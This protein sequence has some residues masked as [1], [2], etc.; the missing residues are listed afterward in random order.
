MFNWQTSKST[1][2]TGIKYV[3]DAENIP[4]MDNSCNIVFDS[5]KGSSNFV[6]NYNV[7]MNNSNTYVTIH[8]LNIQY[9]N[10]NMNVYTKNYELETFEVVNMDVYDVLNRL[11]VH[12]SNCFI[13]LNNTLDVYPYIE[14]LDPSVVAHI[15]DT[16]IT[17]NISYNLLNTVNIPVANNVGF[18]SNYALYYSYSNFYNVPYYLKPQNVAM[19]TTSIVSIT[20]NVVSSVNSTLNSNFINVHNRIITNLKLPNNISTYNKF[21]TVINNNINY[22]GNNGIYNNIFLNTTTSNTIFY[23]DRAYYTGNFIAEK[24]NTFNVETSI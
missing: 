18:G 9:M 2:Y 10:S 17:S 14:T 11:I 1:Y 21:I 24:T 7:V 6:V 16:D 5:Y 13:T 4:S 22:I 20:S 8:P 15:D 3:V 23:N 12:S 19:S